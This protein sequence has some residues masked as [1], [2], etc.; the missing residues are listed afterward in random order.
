VSEIYIYRRRT[1]IKKE[2]R[3]RERERRRTRI[4]PSYSGLHLTIHVLPIQG[5]HIANQI[6][7]K[8]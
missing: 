6:S 2:N 3:E 1:R 7:E 4:I 5:I 8:E